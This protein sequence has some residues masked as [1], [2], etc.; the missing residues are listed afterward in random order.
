M[1]LLGSGIGL[2]AIGQTVCLLYRF[3]VF[4]TKYQKAFHFMFSKR[5]IKIL[6]IL[7]YVSVALLGIFGAN[8]LTL[9]VTLK[10]RS[11]K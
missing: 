5:T 8:K 1:I 4:H 9:T 11:N 3:L 7:L 6:H 10:P 2:I